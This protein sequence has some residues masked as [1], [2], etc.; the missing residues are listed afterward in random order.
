M[1]GWDAKAIVLFSICIT[2]IGPEGAATGVLEPGKF[3]AY[4]DLLCEG[5]ARSSNQWLTF[6]EAKAVFGASELKVTYSDEITKCTSYP[7]HVFLQT[8][9]YEFHCHGRH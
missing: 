7:L 4:L 5:G 8:Y 1:S 3:I 9:P 6:G 2:T